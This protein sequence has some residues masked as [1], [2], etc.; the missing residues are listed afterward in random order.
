M[1]AC[2]ASLASCPWH[3][4][5]LQL[6][7]L[8][9]MFPGRFEGEVP[10]L[11]LPLFPD[12]R[13]HVVSK[14]AMTQT[15]RL[16]AEKLGVRLDAADGSARVSGHSLRVTGAQGLAR[17]GVDTW[18]IQ[19]LG[20]WGSSTVL[21]YVQAVPLELSSA[22][23]RAAAIR[24]SLDEKISQKELPVVTQVSSAAVPVL[25]EVDGGAALDE[26]LVAEEKGKE[27]AAVGDTFVMSDAKIW[28]RVTP[29]GRVGPSQSWA[30]VCGWKFAGR[31]SKNSPA[32]PTV[33]CYKHLCARCLTALRNEL[34]QN[35]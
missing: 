17:A 7:R 34:K 18:A 27:E 32:L 8:R 1:V 15:I 24:Q 20:R 12:A 3:A 22:W 31:E 13:G 28:H 19:L 9:V 4:A 26:A 23:A 35:T 16:A 21:E 33:L 14:E 25:G 29:S 5:H 11:D 10:N 30:A 6:K 2:M